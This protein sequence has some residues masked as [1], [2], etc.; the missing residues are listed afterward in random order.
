M[1]NNVGLTTFCSSL[2]IN[3]SRVCQLR[4][5]PW[6]FQKV[7]GS[8]PSAGGGG[9]G[10]GVG[11][12]CHLILLESLYGEIENQQMHYEWGTQL[13]WEKLVVISLELALQQENSRNLSCWF[14]YSQGSQW[15]QSCSAVG[16]FLFVCLGQIFHLEF[17]KL[18]FKLSSRLVSSDKNITFLFLYFSLQIKNLSKKRTA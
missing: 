6:S 12:G 9:W 17:L 13:F 11:V 7:L 18:M 10:S 5:A 3:L 14:E 8:H 2:L 4:V 15:K 1:E 16:C